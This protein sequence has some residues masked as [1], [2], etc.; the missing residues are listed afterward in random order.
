MNETDCCVSRWLWTCL[1]GILLSSHEY[2]SRLFVLIYVP[3]LF[4]SIYIFFL[5]LLFL[6][7]ARWH[8]W[9]N[10]YILATRGVWRIYRKHPPFSI[11]CQSDSAGES[12][13]LFLSFPIIR[14]IFGESIVLR[15]IVDWMQVGLTLKE[16]HQRANK[17]S[18]ESRLRSDGHHLRWLR[19]KGN[20]KL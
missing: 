13:N 15:W 18:T 1:F 20:E 9:I 2:C 7:S 4:K 3:I 11:K 12:G 6:P 17:C 10:R 19:A 14:L 16:K 5:L 8:F